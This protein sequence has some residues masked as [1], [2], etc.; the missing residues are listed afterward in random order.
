MA[1][2]PCSAVEKKKK[3]NKQKDCVTIVFD[4]QQVC[5]TYADITEYRSS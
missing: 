3:I 4:G 1:K 2:A 5:L